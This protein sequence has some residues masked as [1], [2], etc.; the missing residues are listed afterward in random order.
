M[1][2]GVRKT[3]FANFNLK[4]VKSP[5]PQPQLAVAVTVAVAVA[6]A[7]VVAVAVAHSPWHVACG[8]YFV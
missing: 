2:Q 7:V 6:V 3:W 8:S 4:G 1:S 5:T